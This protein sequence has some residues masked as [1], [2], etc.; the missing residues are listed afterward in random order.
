MRPLHFAAWIAGGAT[1]LGLFFIFV[2]DPVCSTQI[3]LGTPRGWRRDFL[4]EGKAGDFMLVFIAYCLVVM[5]ALRAVETRVL[6][7]AHVSVIPRGIAPFVSRNELLS[8][9]VA[10]RNG[11]RLP[12]R[13]VRWVIDRKLSQDARLGEFPIKGSLTGSNVLFGRGEIVRGARAIE[14][15]ELS[16]FRR[17]GGVKNRWLYVWG[18]VSYDDGFGR[19]RHTNFC[20]RYNLAAMAKRRI[21][22][23]S[24]RQH[25][26]GNNA[27]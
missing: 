6:H 23:G 20:F 10:F 15:A 4:C 8:C 9:D 7:R 2:I 14:F 13:N 16:S 17:G 19:D 22:A 3:A 1:A 5:G 18:R 21:A 24:A 12:A 25:E 26:H 27:N 11:G